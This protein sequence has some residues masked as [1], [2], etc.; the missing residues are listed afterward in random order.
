[1]MA[2]KA[3]AAKPV[4][5]KEAAES[6]KVEPRAETRAAAAAEIRAENAEEGKEVTR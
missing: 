5:T 1:M 3:E 2:E 6:D 4:E